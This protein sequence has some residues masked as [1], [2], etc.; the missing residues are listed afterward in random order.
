MREIGEG[1]IERGGRECV[2]G[3]R[4]IGRRVERASENDGRE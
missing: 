1:V 2:K 4:V 3:E